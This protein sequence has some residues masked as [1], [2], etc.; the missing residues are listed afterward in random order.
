[1]ISDL[2]LDAYRLQEI[3]VRFNEEWLDLDH[4][5]RGDEQ[6]DIVPDFEIFEQADGSK[7]LVG[8]SIHCL[9]VDADTMPRFNEVRI[10]VWGR[11]SFSDHVQDETKA[12]LAQYNTVA[13]LHG[14][15][16]G[17][18]V[19]VTGGAVGGPFIL[20]S[21]NYKSMVERK[22]AETNPQAEDQPDVQSEE[23]EAPSD[24]ACGP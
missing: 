24:S 12:S 15:A 16:R 10:A 2:Q 22:L 14:I 9:G 20:P 13:I 8:L 21:L 19:Q 18:L 1:M 7:L 3:V 6:Y 4:A 5:E 17:T 23:H 11:F